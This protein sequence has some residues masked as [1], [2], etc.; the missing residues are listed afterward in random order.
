MTKVKFKGKELIL[1]LNYYNLILMSKEMGV[2]LPSEAVTCLDEVLTKQKGRTLSVQSMER[3]VIIF[4]HMVNEG[5]DIH[6]LN[7]PD[8]K[9]RDWF[10]ILNDD[11][12]QGVIEEFFKFVPPIET[13]KKKVMAE[14]KK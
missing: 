10:D 7:K 4:K 2:E 1:E 3:F 11:A 12:S 13:V 9:E 14:E 5:C 8:F 6:N